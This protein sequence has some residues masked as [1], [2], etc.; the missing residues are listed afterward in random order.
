MKRYYFAVIIFFGLTSCAEQ[1]DKLSAVPVIAG[2]Y[3]VEKTYEKEEGYYQLH[4]EIAHKYPSTEVM[5]FYESHFKK[6][7]WKPVC[8]NSFQWQK[9]LM[10][11]EDPS[12]SYPTK[13]LFQVMF[14]EEEKKLVVVSVRHNGKKLENNNILWDEE[15]Q[16]V[17]ISL[18]ESR[19]DEYEYLRSFLR[20]LCARPSSE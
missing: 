16:Y 9:M 2:G 14:N 3:N 1:E 7:F 12:K 13:S 8:Q 4:F 17:T 18:S 5:A 15:R 20:E 19:S 10:A 11:N 6:K